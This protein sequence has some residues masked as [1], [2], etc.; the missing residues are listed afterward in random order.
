MKNTQKKRS[1]EQKRRVNAT[2][3]TL[4]MYLFTVVF[5]L[6]PL[7]YML[8]L[9]FMSRD[10]GLGVKAVFTLENYQNIFLPVYETTFAQSIKLGLVTTALVTLIGYPYAYF[11]ARAK[12]KTRKR[13][14]MMQMIPFWVNSLIR[15]YGWI[16]VFRANGLLDKL[17][18]A[19]HITSEPL[20]LLYTY[21]AVLV[22][23]VY[24]LL[25]YMIFSVYN[26][27]EKMDWS[28]VESS[29]DLGA[30]P[31]RAFWDIT[32]KLSLPGLLTGVILTFIPSMGLFFIADILGG[33]KVVLVGNLIQEQLMKAHNQP[34]AAALAVVLMIVTSVFIWL[35][36]RVAKLDRLE[37]DGRDGGGAV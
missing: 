12:E 17:L 34:F 14:L 32:F 7:V 21:P 37:V 23:M 30:S 6:G 5:V 15:L 22:G 31:A 4:P 10:D 13:L 33:N 35:Y 20:R 18:M 25:P 26:S 2:L 29:R 36:R 8:I 24:V 9:S 11:M 3:L 28:L 16:I 19:L 27:I 1:L